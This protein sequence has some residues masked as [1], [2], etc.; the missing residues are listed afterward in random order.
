MHDVW[1]RFEEIGVDY[2]RV[3]KIFWEATTPRVLTM[4]FIE[5]FK[6]TDIPRGETTDCPNPNRHPAR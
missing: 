2:V 1:H 3:P 5:S 6:L 4:E